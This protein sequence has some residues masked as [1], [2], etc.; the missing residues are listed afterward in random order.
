MRKGAAMIRG[1]SMLIRNAMTLMR[2]PDIGAEYAKWLFQ[3]YAL[4]RAP[5]RTVRK[6]VVIGSYCNFG[7]YLSVRDFVGDDEYDFLQTHVFGDGAM[8]DVGANLGV[9]ALILAARDPQREIYAIEPSPDTFA[10]L[11]TNIALNGVKNVICE[12]CAV[13]DKTGATSFNADPRSRAMASIARLDGPHNRMVAAVSL[14]DFVSKHQIERI[15]LL[16]VDVEGYETLVFAGGAAVLGS[17]RP[18]VVYFEICPDLTLR[19]GFDP[20]SAAR[21]LLE[22]RYKLHRIGAQGALV[23]TG[24]EDVAA[25][26]LENWIA[27]PVAT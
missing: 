2:R 15:A 21:I 16:K 19:A 23:P 14:D 10:S 8:I 26:S 27:L 24:L 20:T 22:H 17:L 1:A 3:K 25:T 11:Q 6:D 9:V 12:E 13:S 4:R 5:V 18:A 7:E